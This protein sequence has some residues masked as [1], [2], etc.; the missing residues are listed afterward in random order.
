MYLQKDA[1]LDLYEN[2]STDVRFTQ[3][4]TQSNSATTAGY[5][6]L[7]VYQKLIAVRVQ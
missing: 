2:I 5:T 7:K 3:L 4:L 1:A 6:P